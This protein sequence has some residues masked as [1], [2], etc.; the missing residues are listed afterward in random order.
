MGAQDRS[1]TV[2][3]PLRFAPVLTLALF[4][5]P[6]GAGLIGTVL[7]AFGHMPALGLSGPSLQPWRDLFATPGFGASVRLTLIT[8][9]GATVLSL[10]LAIGFCATAHGR[11]WMTRLERLLAP[12][13]STP[14]AA[15]AIGFAF[16]ILP[17]G[18]IARMISPELTGWARPP[19]LVT[20][21][22]PFGLSLTAGLLL[23]ETPYLVLMIAA[24]SAQVRVR[25]SVAAARVLGYGPAK[26]W[27]A[28][29]LPQICPQIRLPV[30]AVLAFSLSVV[31]VAMVLGPGAPPTLA[32]QATRWFLDY[33]LTLYPH[34]AA[35]AVLQL[36]I[37]A[38]A[39]G[40]WRLAERAAARA[41]RAWLRRG[42]RLDG[43]AAVAG[44]GAG[45]ALAT[46]AA[47]VLAI[48]GMLLWSVAADWRFPDALPAAL[49]TEL[50]LRLEGDLARP[51]WLTVGIGAA[52]TA[53]ALVLVLLCLE[54][55]ER[56]GR[57]PGVSALWLLYLPLLV[58][59]IAFLFGAQVA[60][61]RLGLD[62]TLPA[63]IWAHLLF[64]LPYVFLSLADPFRA[65]D[66]RYVRSA[67]SLGTGPDLA[68]I[69]IKLPMLMKPILIAAAVGFA[70]SVGQY[71]PTLFAGAG[72]VA[73]LTTEAVTLSSGA[74]RRVLG[75]YA[76]LQAFLPLGLYLTALIVPGVIFRNRRGLA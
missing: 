32:V 27:L 9:L 18:W 10:A 72:R 40:L 38:A 60:L 68:V 56:A 26:A 3:S 5:A 25:E 19:A 34:A 15:I 7:P 62:G 59:Q 73:T 23:K 20:V 41:G 75:V 4:L 31:D 74:D 33:D 28:T 36:L 35:A 29:V 11:P 49:T 70:V 14:H 58:P 51:F 71:L 37:V 69:R 1:V 30:F 6:I 48:A 17:S 52:A 50:W 54:H 42:T 64:V 24:A 63:V 16:L 43:T 22:D 21:R 67:A 39:I 45:L 2:R 61:V 53:I 66:P 8:G 65:L 57:R 47:A 44:A 46:G 55:E 76:A 12:L 13:L